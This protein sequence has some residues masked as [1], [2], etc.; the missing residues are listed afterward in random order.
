MLISFLNRVNEFCH[1]NVTRFFPASLFNLVNGF[2]DY[3]LVTANSYIFPS[4]VRH[5]FRE[6]IST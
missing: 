6:H 4:E 5:V 3:T 2:H 1:M